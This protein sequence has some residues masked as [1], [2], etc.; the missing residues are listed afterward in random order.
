MLVIVEVGLALAR[1]PREH[2]TVRVAVAVEVSDFDF[3]SAE[4]EA[5]LVAAQIAMIGHPL[6][7]MAGEG[8]V[9][10]VRTT[11]LDVREI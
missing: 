11:I 3:F 5:Q 8:V 2:R 4:T 6:D 7:N 9:M 1:P 10:P